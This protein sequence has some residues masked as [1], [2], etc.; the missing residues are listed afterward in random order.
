MRGAPQPNATAKCHSQVPG[1]WGG[2]R[3]SRERGW[4]GGGAQVELCPA[5]C[6]Q[7]NKNRVGGGAHTGLSCGR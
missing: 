7:G 1:G 3:G 4:T 2:E 5:D 6:G